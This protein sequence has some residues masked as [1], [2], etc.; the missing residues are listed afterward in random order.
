VDP[1]YVLPLSVS[2][3]VVEM[4]AFYCSECVEGELSEVYIQHPA[5]DDLYKRPG[6]FPSS[7]PNFRAVPSVV[8]PH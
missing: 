3:G 1:R 2:E 5:L 7:L 8:V 4:M 6:P